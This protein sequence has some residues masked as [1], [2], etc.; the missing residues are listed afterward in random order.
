MRPFERWRIALVIGVTLVGAVAILGLHQLVRYVGA[1]T[2]AVAEAIKEHPSPP[3]WQG[4]SPAEAIG[5]GDSVE[6]PPFDRDTA[7]LIIASAAGDMAARC[8]NTAAARARLTMGFEPSGRA[9]TVRVGGNWGKSREGKCL[10][11]A[12]HAVVLPPFA[13][14]P[15]KVELEVTLAP[16][17]KK[18][19]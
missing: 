19:R 6:L 13:G 10:A 14:D 1:T 5:A 18:R 15:S 4:A 17:N 8:G 9:E 3:I 12:M 7:M 2:G 16:N 11:R